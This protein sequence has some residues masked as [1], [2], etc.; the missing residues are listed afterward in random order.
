MWL[1]EVARNEVGFGEFGEVVSQNS[2]HTQRSREGTCTIDQ[3]TVIAREAQ[4]LKTT[5]RRSKSNASQSYRSERLY[6]STELNAHYPLKPQKMTVV[7]HEKRAKDPSPT[8]SERIYTMAE[9]NALTGQKLKNSPPRRS[10]LKGQEALYNRSGSSSSPPKYL[11]SKRRTSPPAP[12]GSRSASSSSVERVLASCQPSLL[13]IA[14]VLSSLGI[15]QDEHLRA[16]ARLRE[17]TRDREMKEEMLKQGVTVL[18]WA[19][20]MDKLQGL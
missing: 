19:I 2:S 7:K 15:R 5:L 10:A 1:E 18:E 12:I 14:P 9:L 6:T 20:L 3:G 11:R 16:L 17:E 13:H 4:N 8:R